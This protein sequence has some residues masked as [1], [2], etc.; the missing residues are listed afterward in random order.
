MSEN[1][2]AEEAVDVKGESVLPVSLG[3]VI[4]GESIESRLPCDTRGDFPLKLCLGAGTE[5]VLSVMP[6]INAKLCGVDAVN[7]SAN[8]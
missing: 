4:V 7:V 5:A 1:L 8:L 2:G 6:G 3:I